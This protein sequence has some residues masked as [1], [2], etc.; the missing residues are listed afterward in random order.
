MTIKIKNI[1]GKQQKIKLFDNTQYTLK[2]DEELELDNY[3]DE[4]E[5]YLY[6]Y[7]SKGLYVAKIIY[8]R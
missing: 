7:L 8:E 6:S 1:T 5:N 3:I 4:Y 2:K